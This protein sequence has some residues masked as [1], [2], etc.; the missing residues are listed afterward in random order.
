MLFASHL[1]W[2]LIVTCMRWFRCRVVPVTRHDE[3]SQSRWTE[4][5]KVIFLLEIKLNETKTTELQD[6]LRLG[7]QTEAL[8]LSLSC[9]Y[10]LRLKYNHSYQLRKVERALSLSDGIS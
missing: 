10:Q 8:S 2:D 7:S 6:A 3:C 9:Y 4:S 1:A 5:P